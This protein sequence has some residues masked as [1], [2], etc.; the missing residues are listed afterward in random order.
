MRMTTVLPVGSSMGARALEPRS[1][2][3][4]KARTPLSSSSRELPLSVLPHWLPLAACVC[5]LVSV[6]ACVRGCWSCRAELAGSCLPAAGRR[7][8]LRV[9]GSGC[10]SLFLSLSLFSPQL[11]LHARTR[12]HLPRAHFTHADRLQHTSLAWERKKEGGGQRQGEGKGKEH[13]WRVK[14]THKCKKSCDFFKCR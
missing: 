10:L 5:G 12:A 8:M 7:G 1:A 6:C 9:W 3:G 14:N 2:P 13:K 11:Y 4:R